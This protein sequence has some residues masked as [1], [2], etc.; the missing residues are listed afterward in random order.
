[1]TTLLQKSRCSTSFHKAGV[2]SSILMSATRRW[3]GAQPS[4]ISLDRRD[5]HSYL[6][7]LTVYANRQ[8]DEIEGLVFV[9]SIP[10]AVT[11]K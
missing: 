8:S 1:M 3:A 11:K 5:Q 6:P 4:L 2:I 7:L 9:G 10:T